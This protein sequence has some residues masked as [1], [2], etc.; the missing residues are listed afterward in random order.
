VEQFKK[1]IYKYII[2]KMKKEISQNIVN[3]TTLKAGHTYVITKPV[4]V[5]AKLTIEDNVNIF[6]LNNVATDTAGN[7][8][9]FA[10]SSELI[11]SEVNFFACGDN[12]E[13]INVANNG[14]LVFNGSAG[15]IVTSAAY[16]S[17]PSNFVAKKIRCNYLGGF[18]PAGSP[19]TLLD[20]LTIANCN[21]DEWNVESVSSYYSGNDGV[22]IKQSTIDFDFLAVQY[23]SAN[24]V[25]NVNSIV[26]I[27]KGLKV[28]N[29]NNYLFNMSSNQLLVANP[30]SYIK[31]PVHTKVYLDGT[32]GSN[33]QNIK[34]VT[35][36]L[37][38]PGVQTAA[39]YYKD[40]T[41]CGQTYIYPT[42]V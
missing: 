18:D 23:P 13:K 36:S 34:V 27:N 19:A 9:T 15:P 31:L 28:V 5:S 42:A 7:G 39:Y 2:Y 17:T 38:T 1:I 33:A 37:P 16:D 20:A 41:T 14:G 30:L 40:C 26:K 3:N 6:I 8:L 35:K 22:V 11:A 10:T 12:M 32:W 21:E 25:T 4:T 29:D 24:G